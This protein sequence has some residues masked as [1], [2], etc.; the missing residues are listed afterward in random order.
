MLMFSCKVVF[1]WLWVP[2]AALMV[3]SR[4]L[5]DLRSLWGFLAHQLET[6]FQG[7]KTGFLVW[8]LCRGLT[9]GVSGPGC[10]RLLSSL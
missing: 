6:L 5:Q 10:G 3:R 2:H 9:E 8:F 7:L 4:P 1:L